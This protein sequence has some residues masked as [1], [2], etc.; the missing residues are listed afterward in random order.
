MPVSAGSDRR[1]G[2]QAR[3]GRVVSPKR[4][5]RRRV[6]NLLHRDAAL[7]RIAINRVLD[8]DAAPVPKATCARE[9]RSKQAPARG[10]LTVGLCRLPLLARHAASRHWWRAVLTAL[11]APD[12][13]SSGASPIS[14]GLSRCSVYSW[15]RAPGVSFCLR[16]LGGF[17]FNS[18]LGC[19]LRSFLFHRHA[20][21][22]K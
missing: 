4:L 20:N 21:L 17:G 15:A 12:S 16:L 19:L 7:C 8:T 9:G 22:H 2:E 1:E 5:T 3:H 18:L 11:F 6:G 14:T 10:N 13:S